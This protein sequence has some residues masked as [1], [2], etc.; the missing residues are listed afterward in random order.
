MLPRKD[1]ILIK[2]RI[3]NN[4]LLPNCYIASTLGVNIAEATGNRTTHTVRKYGNTRDIK[5]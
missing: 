4:I 2:Y 5:T 3:G 1:L